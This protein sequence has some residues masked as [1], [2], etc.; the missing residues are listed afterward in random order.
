MYF[1]SNKIDWAD[2][3]TFEMI[4]NRYFKDKNDLYTARWEVIKS[5]DVDSYFLIIQTQ[6]L[7]DKNWLYLSS[8]K[9][10]SWAD[11]ESFVPLW[12]SYYKDVYSIYYSKMQEEWGRSYWEFWSRYV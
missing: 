8:W 10:F 5:I 4:S 3:E 6:V 9:Y 7:F 1:K 2:P 11:V 12:D